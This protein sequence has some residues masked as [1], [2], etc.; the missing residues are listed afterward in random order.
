MILWKLGL[1]WFQADKFKSISQHLQVEGTC[2]GKYGFLITVL[3]VFG[4][5]EKKG[6]IR[7]GVGSA[8]FDVKYNCVSFMPHKGETLDAVVKSVNKVGKLLVGTIL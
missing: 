5:G 4:Y 3:R 1:I 7:E 8:V 6:I 2:T